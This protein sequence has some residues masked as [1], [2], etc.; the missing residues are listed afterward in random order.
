[1]CAERKKHCANCGKTLDQHRKDVFVG[2][3][4][5]TRQCPLPG[6]IYG[7]GHPL[8]TWYDNMFWKEKVRRTRR[9]GT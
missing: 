9:Y 4:D 1:M 7:V 3:P 2:S 8:F 5:T 6:R